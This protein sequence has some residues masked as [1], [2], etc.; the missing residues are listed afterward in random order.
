MSL[1][2]DPT[3]NLELYRTR[4][5]D[6]FLKQVTRPHGGSRLLAAAP[7]LY[8]PP[9]G[10][11]AD[12]S[13]HQPSPFSA[14]VPGPAGGCVQGAARGP[15]RDPGGAGGDGTRDRRSGAAGP[16]AP[17]GRSGTR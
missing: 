13:P 17:A 3:F 6:L 7:G 11:K 10:S 1:T 8:C 14:A 12:P 2:H 16:S 15:H 9:P 5:L 4:L